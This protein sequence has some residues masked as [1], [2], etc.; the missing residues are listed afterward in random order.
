VARYFG[1]SRGQVVKI[2]RGEWV[3]FWNPKTL[4]PRTRFGKSALTDFLIFAPFPPPNLQRPKLLV[5]TA[6]IEFACRNF[7]Q[8]STQVPAFTFKLNNSFVSFSESPQQKKS[9]QCFLS[10][11]LVQNPCIL[12]LQFFSNLPTK[13]QRHFSSPFVV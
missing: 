6:L 3:F 2:T 9:S 13:N 8:H 1:L 10:L 11:S 7:K 12:Y 5:V 4:G